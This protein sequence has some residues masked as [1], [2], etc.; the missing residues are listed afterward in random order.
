MATLLEGLLSKGIKPAMAEQITT[1][2]I[3]ITLKIEIQLTQRMLSMTNTQI[4]QMDLMHDRLQHENIKLLI[5][6][7]DLKR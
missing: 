7:Q 2:E 6:V 4:A 1:L 3:I 5:P